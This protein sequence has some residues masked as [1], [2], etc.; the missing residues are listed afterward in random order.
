MEQLEKNIVE[1][2][3][4]FEKIFPP[5][6]FDSMEH[7]PIHLAYEAKVGGPV[8]YR[9]MYPFE[10]FLH[11]L[12]KKTGNRAQV[13][14]S[15]VEAYMIEEVSTFC[16]AYFESHVSTRLNRVSRNDDGGPVDPGNLFIS[17][18][19]GRPL[20]S[21]VAIRYLDVDELKAAHRYVLLNH[22]K[23]DPY[24]LIT[25]MELDIIRDRDFPQWLL[26]HI[27]HTQNEV[28]DVIRKLANGPSRRVSCYKGYFV[29]GFKFH[30]VE[31][32]QSKATT[33]YGVCVLGS[34][35]SE[36]EVDYYGLLEEV[37]ELE[38]LDWGMPLHYLSATAKGQDNSVELSVANTF[39]EG[40]ASNP[41]PI[42]VAN[43]LD[44][45]NIILDEEAEEVNSVEFEAL[46]HAMDS[47]PT[48]I[49]DEEHDEEEEF[50]EIESEED[51][52]DDE[53][54]NSSDSDK[55]DDWR[56]MIK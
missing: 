38:Y 20:G 27:Q 49:G 35:Y 14:A 21:R 18:H 41:Q 34:T 12:K 19:P 13:E 11:H 50:E 2:L 4:K 1:I 42:F 22:D 52:Q 43:D 36:C 7:L 25:D 24:L 9:W 56:L 8:Q 48:R 40:E 45:I 51:S 3:C 6:F 10:R 15:I 33:N 5:G 44:D 54:H 55:D 26:A 16:S 28:D 23:I 32:G 47:Y 29:N 46:R 37:V 30:T 53:D 31:Y 39:Q 17:T